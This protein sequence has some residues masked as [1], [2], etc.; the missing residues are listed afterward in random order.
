LDK[1]SQS[2]YQYQRRSL[3]KKI[4]IG[5]VLKTVFHLRSHQPGYG[6]RKLHY[7]LKQQGIIIG[8][9]GLRQLLKEK[10][11]LLKPPKIITSTDY[12]LI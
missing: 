12:I 1:S 11:L 9:D 8:R 2:Y 3:E 7:C 4:F 5:V 10:G 6:L